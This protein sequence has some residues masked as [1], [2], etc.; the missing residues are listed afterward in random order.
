MKK[1]KRILSTGLLKKIS[2]FFVFISVIA[3]SP[4]SW[5][6]FG[7]IPCPKNLKKFN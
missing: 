6:L 4:P 5:F 2:S 1:N 3:A 7:E